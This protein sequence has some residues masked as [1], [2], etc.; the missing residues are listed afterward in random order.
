MQ[1][2]PIKKGAANPLLPNQSINAVA[3]GGVSSNAVGG[4]GASVPV[5]NNNENNTYVKNI[6]KNP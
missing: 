5:G 2:P 4:P 3:G 6:K 1:F